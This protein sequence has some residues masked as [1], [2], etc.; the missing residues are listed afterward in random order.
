M[1]AASPF[2]MVVLISASTLRANLPPFDFSGLTALANA[3]VL[4]IG[5]SE[6]VPGFEIRLLLNGQPIYHRAFGDWSLNR[7]AKCDSSTKT[8]TG[9]LMVSLAQTPTPSGF[10]LD[11]R[12]STYIPALRTAEKR[13]ITVRQAFSHTSGF[14]SGIDSLVLLNPNIT[15]QQAATLLAGQ[16]LAYTP[17]T[18]FDYG[19][20]SMQLAGAAAETAAGVPFV[21]LLEDRIT[22]PLAMASTRFYLASETN[23]RVDGGLESTATDFSR[24]MDMLLNNGTDRGTGNFILQPASVAAM[25]ARQTQDAMPILNSPVD[26]S[27]YG[28]GVWLDQLGQAGPAVDYLAAGARGFHSWIDASEGL[29]FTFATD[30]TRF[31][32]VEFLSSR[33]HAEILRVVPEP[34]GLAVL[35]LPALALPRPRRIVRHTR[36]SPASE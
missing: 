13:D 26:N 21:R 22:T 11:S 4:G 30:T 28:I 12:L 35:S 10:S 3:A 1:R 34:A 18:A 5:T 19:S 14:D 8:V 2:V 6:P 25:F 36:S 23:P 20:V 31:S 16:P 9:A 32:N 33:M 15:L 7:V 27:R 17:G 24:F 29:V